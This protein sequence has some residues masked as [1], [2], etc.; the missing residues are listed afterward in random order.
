VKAARQLQGRP[1]VALKV[2]TTAP[3]PPSTAALPKSRS[4]YCTT[5]SSRPSSNHT[6]KL[7]APPYVAS[8]NP[9]QLTTKVRQG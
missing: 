7:A 2:P 6:W 1:L 8:G 9:S 4:A 3:A 5:T